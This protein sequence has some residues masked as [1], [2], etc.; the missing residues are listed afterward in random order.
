MSCR[1]EIDNIFLWS[2]WWWMKNSWREK[3]LSNMS[4]SSEMR[5]LSFHKESELKCIEVHECKYS[6]S[7]EGKI[8]W[9]HA[10]LSSVC[11]IYIYIYIYIY[12]CRTIDHICWSLAE[13]DADIALVLRNSTYTCMI[14][15]IQRLVDSMR[16]RTQ[17]KTMNGGHTKW[18]RWT[19]E[20]TRNTIPDGRDNWLDG[21]SLCWIDDLPIQRFTSIKISVI[22][23]D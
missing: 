17:G 12:N 7:Y 8:V 5:K 20:R 10:L 14:Q 13:K 11:F 23:R 4:C 15:I 21:E 22:D 19:K 2:F 16:D 1:F 18:N 6:S 3:C 9:S